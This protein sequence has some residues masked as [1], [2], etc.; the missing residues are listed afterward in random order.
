MKSSFMRPAMV[1]ALALG[2][3]ACGGKA[4]FELGGVISGLQYDGLVLTN[5]DAS[6]LKV[7]AG[8]T[9]F[10]FPN[11]IDYGA[12]YDVK[13]KTNPAHQTCVLGRGVDTA[14]RLATI[15]I[16]IQCALQPHALG[17]TVSGLTADGLVLTNGSNGLVTVAKSTT[18]PNFES[19]F[20]LPAV[21]YGDTY[22][23]S[24]LSQPSGGTLFCSVGPTGTGKM[25]D[26]DVADIAVTCVP[27]TGT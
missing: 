21:L 17:G 18:G 9:T 26:T 11:T 13:I 25:G 14:G 4:S 1:L 2:L 15:Q 12:S 27:R 3:A 7:A 19:K 10:R 5:N 8:V 6:D 22:G 20:S 23:V 24:V 16:V